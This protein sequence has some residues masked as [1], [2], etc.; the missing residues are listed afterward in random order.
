MEMCNEG[1]LQFMASS[2]MKPED[3]QDRW[4]WCLETESGEQLYK[5]SYYSNVSGKQKCRSHLNNETQD[6]GRIPGAMASGT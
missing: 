5:I 1:I 2:E 6:P 4:E 3:V